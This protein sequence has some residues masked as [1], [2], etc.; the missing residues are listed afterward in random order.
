LE[1][2]HP[3][4]AHCLPKRR[5]HQGKTQHIG[6]KP[7]GEQQSAADEHQSAVGELATREGSLAH[8]HPGTVENAEPLAAN[9][10]GSQ[11]A[12]EQNDGQGGAQADP[13]LDRRQ[14][15]KFDDR[16]RDEDEGEA[17]VGEDTAT[18]ML[19]PMPLRDLP[20]VD[21]L[22]RSLPATGLP[23]SLVVECARTAIDRAREQINQGNEADPQVIARRLVEHLHARRPR[24]VIN[25]SGV[26]LHTNLGR[27]PLAAEA[28]EAARVA[29]TEYGNVE[30][31]LVTGNRGG[32]G[33]YA[34]ELA[35]T[36]TGAEAAL[37]VNNNAAGLYLTLTALAAG[38]QV[39]V[40][41]GELIEIGGSYRL[42][43]LMAATGAVMVEVGTTNRTH[44]ADYSAAVT[45]ATA[46]LLKVHTSNYRVV[47]FTEEVGLAALAE[48]AH[49]HDLPL[50]YDVG[51][52]LLDETVPWLSGPP[53]QWLADEPGVRQ[54][55]EQGADLVL[56]SGD[57]LLGGPQA[58]VLVGRDDL[59]ERLAKHPVARALRCDGS[60]LA[61]MSATLQMYADGRGDEIPFWA[62]AAA[63]PQELRARLEKVL[64]GSGAEGEIRTGESVPGAGSVPGATVPSP[65]LVVLAPPADLV[66]ARL[67]MSELPV[68]ARREGGEL[69][70]DVRTVPSH[71]DEVLTAALQAACRS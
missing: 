49:R 20:S 50:V 68:I 57:K 12:G 70:I 35:R 52:G 21:A 62:M 38:R 60:T 36:L 64:A 6:E 56:F 31:D 32:R 71:L 51:S 42:P 58:G 3:P 7:G 23:R 16:H 17:H 41:R 47:G 25:A 55:L 46:M 48:L 8:L 26:L 34:R 33:G 39:P 30:Y 18:G 44:L 54:A 4:Q 63:A 22:V 1:E 59:V 53:P 65:V 66:W 45:E 13:I 28:A 14:D 67:L 40:S 69:V 10:R 37:I 61:A 5:H 43:E 9:Q 29:A 11:Y 24:P 15:E 27:A 19:C 2:C